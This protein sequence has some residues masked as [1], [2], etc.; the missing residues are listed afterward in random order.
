[1][2]QRLSLLGVLLLL[3][4]GGLLLFRA[5]REAEIRSGPDA[6]ASSPPHSEESRL[7]TAA[8]GPEAARSPIPVPDELQDLTTAREEPEEFLWYGRIIDGETQ[9]P[10]VEAFYDLVEEGDPFQSDEDWLAAPLRADGV[11]ELRIPRLEGVVV[12]FGSSGYAVRLLAPVPDRGRADSPEVVELWRAAA[13]E[14]RIRD[15]RPDKSYPAVAHILV[16][17]R[18][19]FTTGK[20]ISLGDEIIWEGE[21]AGSGI[22]LFEDLPPAVELTLE[23]TNGKSLLYRQKLRLDPGERRVLEFTLHEGCTIEGRALD[24]DGQ[25]VSDLEV[26]LV[27]DP[28]ISPYF[29]RIEEIQD[30]TRTNEHGE[31]IFENVPP[32]R[33]F[34]G[35]AAVEGGAFSS[36]VDPG[37]REK[38]D[39][40]AAIAPM[41]V[42]VTI[43]PGDGIV[44]VTLTCWSGLYI[45]GR[46]LDSKGQPA[47]GAI[48]NIQGPGFLLSSHAGENGDFMAGPLVPGSYSLSAERFLGK[49]IGPDR[50]SERVEAQP[51]D[52]DV[53]L[54]LRSGGIVCV[55]VYDEQDRPASGVAGRLIS[56]EDEYEGWGTMKT[57]ENGMIRFSGV[58]VGTYVFIGHRGSQIAVLT[59][60]EMGLELGERAAWTRLE[61]ATRMT[62]ARPMTSKHF[63][64][65]VRYGGWMIHMGGF[66]DEDPSVLVPEGEIEVELVRRRSEREFDVVERKAVTARAGETPRVEFSATVSE[67]R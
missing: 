2:S 47:K 20:W 26:W 10:L 44:P 52:D 6:D 57:D 63:A 23:A 5:E 49:D 33:W 8:A 1:M 45:R 15:E 4:A 9:E 37:E 58:G 62:I 48:V 56:S 11:L 21:P 64:W 32:G 42:P 50:A 38:R 65:R 18:S 19:L 31:F 66:I 40:Q 13:L 61:P 16:R 17:D 39:A 46:V 25:P 41:S 3:L 54:R 59:G 60:V 34:V 43:R 29:E 51:G 36:S 28:K 22:F 30:V 24:G 7:P 14:A 53:E 12:F 67:D 55:T 35:P 27:Q